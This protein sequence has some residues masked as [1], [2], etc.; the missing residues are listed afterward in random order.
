MS[1]K[2]IKDGTVGDAYLQLLADRG[3]DYFFGNAGTDFA[4]LIE[5]FAK[6]QALG[7]PVPKA[8]MVPHENVAIHMAMGYTAVTG[9]PQVVMVHVNVGTANSLNGLINASRGNIPV[10]FS[11]GR[12]PYTETGDKHGK[13]TREVHWPQEMFDQGALAREMVKWDYELR[14]KAVLET[15][16]DRAIN[17]AMSEPKGPVYLTLPREPLAETFDEFTYRSPSR[18][19]TPTPGHP[20]PEAIDQAAELL[21]KAKNP[22]II[23]QDSGADPNSVAPL[24]A[25]AERFAIP[26]VQRKHRY[27]CLP[28]N[29]P[30]HLGYDSDLFLDDADVILVASCD[31]PWI[32]SVKSPRDDCTI[33][34]MGADPIFGRYPIRGYESDLAI[35]G[36]MAPGFQLLD[37]ALS[38]REKAASARIDS[39]RKAM[40]EKRAGLHEGYK[41][42]LEKSRNS[43]PLAP[44]YIASCINQAKTDDSIVITESAFAMAQVE[45]NTPGSFFSGGAGGGLGYGLGMALGAKLAAPEKLVICTQ[46]DGA[47]MYGNPVP[48]HYTGKA[49]GLPMLTVIMNNEEW[50][51][52]K[53]NTRGMYPDGY[54]AKSNNEPLTF[55]EPGTQFEKA[56]EMSGGYGEMVD[57]PDELPKALDR[58]ID[59]VMGQEKQAVLNVKCA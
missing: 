43:R 15:V 18:R 16:V 14:D 38:T 58:A 27:L 7:T 3:I 32:P 59:Q 9:R 22:V 57:D 34:Q 47:Y 31:V 20:D 17:M 55:F 51:A 52:V 46:G 53:R 42:A 56:A 12:T 23:T 45:F 1:N 19:A 5:S 26:V 50:G 6:A 48:A 4:P 10:I 35:T 25:L 44:A 36:A 54:A 41:A 11:S 21:A 37:D 30:M 29:H 13:R 24:A 39:R 2:T 49:E 40:A 28:S 33:I 8:I